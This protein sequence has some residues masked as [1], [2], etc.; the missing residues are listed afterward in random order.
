[1][2]GQHSSCLFIATEPDDS[3]MKSIGKIA[4]LRALY[5]A[6]ALYLLPSCSFAESIDEFALRYSGM[7]AKE[8]PGLP[9]TFTIRYKPFQTWY[10]DGSYDPNAELLV[11]A[12][13][14]YMAT[15]RIYARCKETGKYRA[16]TAAGTAIMVSQQ[17][18]EELEIT[19][20]RTEKMF[21]TVQQGS[22]QRSCQIPMSPSQ[23]RSTAEGGLWFE[24][25][26][27]IGDFVTD[28]IVGRRT[29]EVSP[30]ARRPIEEIINTTQILGAIRAWRVVAPDGNSVLAEYLR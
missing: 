11:F 3:C 4:Y 16:Q 6:I 12:G 10:R 1:M 7:Y 25:V 20:V 19:E 8:I 24:V 26:F 15:E 13:G 29:R 5:L 30:N 2:L 27:E 17:R 23:Y 22:I 28:P 18:C 14:C 9:K 21:G